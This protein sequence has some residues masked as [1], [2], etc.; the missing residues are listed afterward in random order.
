MPSS[1]GF[2]WGEFPQKPKSLIKVCKFKTSYEQLTSK[3]GEHF[4]FHMVKMLHILLVYQFGIKLYR[5]FFAIF[6]L[7]FE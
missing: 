2:T 5:S 1:Y 6:C 7:S 3:V 4:H